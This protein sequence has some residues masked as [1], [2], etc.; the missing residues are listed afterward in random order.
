MK[1][2]DADAWRFRKASK[3]MRAAIV[4]ASLLQDSV[5]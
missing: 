2:E 3:K 5:L 4:E 1:F